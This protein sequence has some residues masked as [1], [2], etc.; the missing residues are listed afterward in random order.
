MI[1]VA[2]VA[3]VQDGFCDAGSSV[4][5]TVLEITCP[6][7]PVHLSVYEPIR[8]DCPDPEEFGGTRYEPDACA[9]LDCAYDIVHDVTLDVL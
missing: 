4:M 8:P 9:P 2:D 5:V 3:S 6:F 7:V 1:E